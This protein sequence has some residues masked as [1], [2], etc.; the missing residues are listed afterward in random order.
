[1]VYNVVSKKE[2]TCVHDTSQHDHPDSSYTKQYTADTHCAGQQCRYGHSQTCLLLDVFTAA[3]CSPSSDPGKA[4]MSSSAVT[5]YLLECL[6]DVACRAHDSL[7]QMQYTE[8]T[9]AAV[10]QTTIL[11]QMQQ[12]SQPLRQYRGMPL[13]LQH[14]RAWPLTTRSASKPLAIWPFL[15]AIP[16]IWLGFALHHLL[17]CN[18]LSSSGA[19]GS[20][21]LTAVQVAGSTYCNPAHAHRHT[22]SCANTH[23]THPYAHTPPPHTQG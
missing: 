15:G 9:T 22:H 23:S 4:N 21:F 2:V 7:Q 3:C 17:S 20:S 13:N 6:H 11:Q 5:D 10:E 1:M 8:S 16:A 14:S 19:C 18:K 12:Q